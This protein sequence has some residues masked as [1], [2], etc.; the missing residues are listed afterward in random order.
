MRTQQDATG[1]NLA[2]LSPPLS[3]SCVLCAHAYVRARACVRARV[4]TGVLDMCAAGDCVLRQSDCLRNVTR[5]DGV[6]SLAEF[7]VGAHLYVTH[8]LLTTSTSARRE[9]TS[10]SWLFVAAM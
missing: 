1:D 9:L 2:L 6:L 10:T 4:S 8:D 3:L 7:K 5:R